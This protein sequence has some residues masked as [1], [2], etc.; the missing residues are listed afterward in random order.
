MPGRP[1]LFATTKQ[2][3]D[4][5]GLTSNGETNRRDLPAVFAF[6]AAYEFSPKIKTNL[7]INYYF[8]QK[9][10]WGKSSML[11][12]EAPLSALAGDAAVYAMCFQYQASPKF[13]ASF[14]GGYTKMN[15]NDKEGYYTNVGTFEVVQSDNFNM[16]M[17]CAYK[18]SDKIRVNV[19][20][21]HTFYPSDQKI[22]ALMAQPLD[23]DVIVNN[24]I[25][26]LAIGIDFTF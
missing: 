17:G 2:F 15:F 3:L 11:T 1:A 6:G 26:A 10:D 20:Y 9:A 22:K 12:N 14:G 8:Q 13:L 5:L 7:D 16:N 25:N 23:V 4:D 19:G 21:M 18:T 24:C